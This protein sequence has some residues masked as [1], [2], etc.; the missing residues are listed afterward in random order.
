MQVNKKSDILIRLIT[1]IFRIIVGGTFIFSGFVKAIDP[2]GTYYK[3]E[4]YMQALGLPMLH[5]IL[6]T[7]VFALCALEFIIGIFMLLGCYR[8]SNP[9]VAMIFMSVMLPLTLWIWISNPVSDCGCFGDYIILSN[10]ATFWKNVVLTLMIVWLLKYNIRCVSI[11]SPAFQWMGCVASLLYVG[12]IEFEGY[13]VQPL[14]DF[15]AY[16]VGNPLFENI[17]ASESEDNYP[18]FVFVYKHG[19]EF[20]EFSEDDE[21]PDEDEGWEYVE[22][23]EIYADTS[24]KADSS[25]KDLQKSLRIW[26]KE[27]VEDITDQITVYPKILVM[28][29]P[30]LTTIS[31]ATTWTINE[32]YDWSANNNV[33]MIAV[34]SGSEEEIDNWEDLSIP[35]YPIYTSDDTTLK[36]LA[37]GNPAL[38]YIDDNIIK[39][40]STLSSIDAT[41]FDEDS[42]MTD[43]NTFDFD[44]RNILLNFTYLYLAIIS[45]LI[46]ISMLPRLKNVYSTGRRK[47]IHD[48][49]VHD[50]E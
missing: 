22:R 27:G 38:I 12:Y 32:I 30:D 3:F 40:K 29:I 17:N 8:R 42:K 25:Q 23:K 41:K 21:L 49:K 37:R 26:D 14:L 39:W 48:D 16:S 50:V 47:F 33:E 28:S 44:G 35:Q 19:D 11:I 6:V 9:V 4:E 1:W 10:A 31:P 7:G 18:R 34:V 20:K 15:R 45:V 36:E 13:T 2:W 46:C 43:L 5:T 24:A